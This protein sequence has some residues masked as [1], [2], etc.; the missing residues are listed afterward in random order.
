MLLSADWV[1]PIDGEPIP[2]GAVHVHNARIAEVGPRERFA[3][4]SAPRFD[5][6]GCTIL[7]GLVNA[8][9]H[10]SL[11]AL[12]G[13]VSPTDF[14]AWLT[15]V[16]PLI[17]ALD[18]DDM[19]A[20]ATLGALRCL[21][22]GITVVGDIAYG[23]EAVASA[24]DLGVGGVFYWEVLGIPAEELPGA[25]ERADFPHTEHDARG[26]RTRCGLSP[27]TAYTSG[28][29]L[30]RAVARFAREHDYP[31]AIHVAES[32]AESQLLRDGTGP[33]APV[34]A[35]LADRFRPPAATPVE[36]L[37]RLGVLD[38][39]LAVHCVQL[40][41]GDADLLAAHARGAALC[42]RSNEFLHNGQ[43]PVEALAHTRL[44]L[45]VGSDSS[46]SNAG[47]DLFA[48]ARALRAVHPLSPSRLLRMMTLE[49]ATAL[50]VETSFGSLTPGKQADL[51]VLRTGATAEPVRAVVERGAPGDVEA[52]MS[53]GLWRVREGR[54]ALN[55]AP[56]EAAGRHATE[57]ARTA[58]R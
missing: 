32:P 20:S 47:I 44:P 33:L 42:P 13:L 53:A 1:L 40:G 36:Y 28:P 21:E 23:P 18:E 17:A 54:P 48:E 39:A 38:D 51:L 14:A 4:L 34:A 46:A 8:H 29:E 19:A 11:T 55:T 31:L 35:R 52:V 5:F 56:I 50:G 37:T 7:P 10:L 30:L 22:S 49:G 16:V 27:H 3:D 58:S 57:K 25:L 43:P 2:D 45:A 41:P 24:A 15:R 6:P 9:T 12:G 26:G